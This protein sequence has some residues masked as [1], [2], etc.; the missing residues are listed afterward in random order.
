M[1]STVGAAVMNGAAMRRMAVGCVSS[2]ASRLENVEGLE[3][4]GDRG[5]TGVECGLHIE[6]L[7][8]DCLFVG[9]V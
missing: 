7:G 8:L 9:V 6:R 1:M 5:G 3:M 4:S 2:D